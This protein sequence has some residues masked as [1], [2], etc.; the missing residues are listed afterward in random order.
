MSMCPRCN[1]DD[2]HLIH[3]VEIR[4]VYDGVLY[5]HCVVCG[6]DWPR[7]DPPDRR[8][9]AAKDV[10]ARWAAMDRDGQP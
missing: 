10:L 6:H 4:G 1:N 5:W 8:H 2:Q 3:G 7:F 9:A